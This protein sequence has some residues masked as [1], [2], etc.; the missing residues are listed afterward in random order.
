MIAIIQARMSSKRLPGKVFKEL[1]GKPMLQWTLER[2]G[3]SKMLKKVVVATSIDSGDNIVE[4]FCRE[5][6]VNYHRGSLE[7]VA[8][9]FTEVAK[10][11]QADSFVRISGDSPFI[12]PEIIDQAIS[13]FRSTKV[14]LVTNIMPRTFPK[15]QSVEVINSGY[16]NKLYERM[17]KKTDKEHVTKIFYK[18]PEKHRIVSF[19]SGI[20]A[21]HVQLS[22]DTLDDFVEVEKLI[23][24]SNGQPGNWKELLDLKSTL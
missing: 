16:F 21:G 11:E 24:L 10:S 9:R 20:D 7:N 23:Q 4:E 6:N 2:L 1:A 5:K 19:T 18:N 8:L 15:G 14:E 22:V 12:D 13:L 3:N 17:T